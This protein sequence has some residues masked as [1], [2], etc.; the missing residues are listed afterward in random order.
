MHGILLKKSHGALRDSS[1]PSPEVSETNEVA[2]GS[3]RKIDPRTEFVAAK[4]KGILVAGRMVAVAR[5]AKGLEV[6]RSPL[7]SRPT[8]MT[9]KVRS[10]KGGPYLKETEM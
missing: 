7:G 1:E 8:A 9:L 6:T 2:R 3:G 5:A 4:V 10:P